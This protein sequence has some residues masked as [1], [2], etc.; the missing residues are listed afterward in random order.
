MFA[1]EANN[2]DVAKKGTAITVVLGNPPYS[3]ISS[4]NT[5]WITKQ[6]E[7][8]KYIDGRH[9]N[10]RKTWL[11]DDYVRFIRYG[12]VLIE[13]SNIGILS[14]INPHGFG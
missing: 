3:G 13:E 5:A 10:E 1:D 12:E 14:Y 9:I 7:Q 8:Y 6:I 2:A 11:N 4:N